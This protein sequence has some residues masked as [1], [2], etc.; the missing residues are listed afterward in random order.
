MG[1]DL[2][3]D[4]LDSSSLSHIIMSAGLEGSFPQCLSTITPV[5]QRMARGLGSVGE[6]IVHCPSTLPMWLKLSSHGSG[7]FYFLR[8]SLGY[9]ER[10]FQEI[11]SRSFQGLGTGTENLPTYSSGQAITETP[12]HK[13]RKRGTPFSMEGVSKL[14]D[15][16]NLPQ[17]IMCDSLFP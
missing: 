3:G 15:I 8:G 6:P 14:M 1:K 9:Q 10:M 12:R 5:P 13:S 4:Q 16:F 11:R 17:F 7:K 2:G